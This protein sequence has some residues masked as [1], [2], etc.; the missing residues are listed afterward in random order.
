MRDADPDGAG[1]MTVTGLRLDATPIGQVLRERRAHHGW[2]LAEVAAKTGVSR[3]TLSKLENDLITPSYQTIL[4]LCSGLEIEIGDLVGRPGEAARRPVMGRRSI[5]R[6]H[7]GSLI[8]D[9]NYSYTYLC[10]EVAHKRII[11]MVIDVRA[12]SISTVGGLWNHVGE[13]FVYVLEGAIR[14]HTEFYETEVLEAGDCAYFD[15]TMG[16]AYLSAGDKPARLLVTCSSATP[17]LA[18][19]LREVLKQRL[20]ARADRESKLSDVPT[21]K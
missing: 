1:S 13:E 10:T 4:Q 19:T 17:N 11:P 9:E 3:S 18:Q 21:K 14:L 7:A 12:N 16:H 20:N 15:S 8:E 6:G 2:T 5:S